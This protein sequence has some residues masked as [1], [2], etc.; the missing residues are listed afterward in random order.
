MS[1]IELLAL[2]VEIKR[3]GKQRVL[4]SN[5]VTYV[6]GFGVMSYVYLCYFSSP[7]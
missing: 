1:D 5:H 6:T 4:E 2:M 3:Y 7:H